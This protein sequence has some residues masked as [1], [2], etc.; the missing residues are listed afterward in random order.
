MSSDPIALFDFDDVKLPT[1]RFNPVYLI[2]ELNTDFGYSVYT[3]YSNSAA[4]SAALKCIKVRA[5]FPC[6]VLRGVFRRRSRWLRGV[7]AAACSCSFL[8]GFG[9]FSF[10]LLIIGLWSE[11][12]VYF[13][14]PR[15]E[16]GNYFFRRCESQKEGS[17]TRSL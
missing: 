4:P 2:A 11:E 6:S 3:V 15:Y 5:V 10:L 8:V 7:L 14:P 9:R 16:R 17:L 12:T 13:H 1:R